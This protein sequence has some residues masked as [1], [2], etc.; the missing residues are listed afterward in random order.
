MEVHT[1]SSPAPGGA[2]TGKMKF[3]H[4]LWEFIMLFLAVFCGFLAEYQLEHKI[5]KDKEK[6][7][8][9]S[10]LSD[11]KKD[12]ALLAPNTYVGPRIIQYSDSLIEELQK[13]PLQGREKRVYI[14]LSLISDGLT[15]KYYDRTVSQLRYSG[16]FRLIQKQDVSNALLDYDVLMREAVSYAT[17]VESWSF[18]TPALQKSA[19]IF[20]INF[21]FKIYGE[22]RLYLSQPDSVS[23][24]EIPALLTYDAKEIKVFSSLQRIA[25]LTDESKLDYS[26]RALEKNKELDSLIRKEYNLK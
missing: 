2:H 9:K 13:V 19:S 24:P 11:L 16:G 21:V 20:D 18:V 5:E 3:T 4:Y 23:F 14:F 25:Q 17:S 26:I 6:E 15:F 8:I 1:H 22:A 10:L 7:F 12:S